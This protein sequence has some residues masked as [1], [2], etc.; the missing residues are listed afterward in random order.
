M[1]EVGIMADLRTVFVDD[2]LVVYFPNHELM[3]EDQ[4]RRIGTELIELTAQAKSGKMLVSFRGVDFVTSSMLG[5]L[6]MLNKRCM[7]HQIGLKICDVGPD[8]RTI[9]RIVR[10]DTLVDICGDEAS[11]LLAFRSGTAEASK[12]DDL[13]TAS[14]YQ[15]AADAGDAA[16]QFALGKCY[17][18]GRG[19]DQDFH[20]ALQWYEK[21]AAL[22][23]AAAQHALGTCYAYGMEVA[24]DYQKALGWFQKAAEQG[25]PN[26]QYMLGVSYAHGLAGTQDFALAVQWYQRAA[27][28]G[29]LEAQVNLAEAYL[30]GRGIEQDAEQ[31]MRWLRAAAERGHADAQANLAWFYVDGQV[32]EKDK[33]QAICWYRQAA[34]QGHQAAEQALRDLE[35]ETEV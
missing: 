10:L 22:G 9:F 5:Q 16:A 3:D 24:Q 20:Q 6:V 32:V 35:D 4:N 11:A 13:Y 14:D 34:A 25:H 12:L 19:V 31:A 18:E 7:S 8:L 17:E 30:E 23:H 29:D 27:E 33:D 28:A 26:S 15:S 2:V 21:S 1:L